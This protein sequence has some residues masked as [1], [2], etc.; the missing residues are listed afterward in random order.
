MKYSSIIRRVMLL[1]GAYALWHTGVSMAQ[2]DGARVPLAGTRPAV[3][4]LTPQEVGARSDNAPAVPA[5]TPA[6]ARGDVAELMQLIHDANLSELRTTYNGSYG[7]SL[8]FYPRQITYYVAL[9]QNKHFWRVIRSDSAE[10]AEAIYAAFAQQTQQLADVE[11]RRTR[12]QAQNA[13][14]Q[15]IIAISRQ[16]AQ[17]LQADLDVARTQ[18]ATVDDRQR[19]TH[20]EALALRAERDN[21]Q[22]QLGQLRS[23]VARLQQQTEAGLPAPR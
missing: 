3:G 21:A 14:L 15:G 13:N 23:E 19:Q 7:A 10:R 11:I 20:D 6:A 1:A 4:E 8:F 12:L 22:A 16:Q 9:F 5:D 2:Q 18:Q 17:R